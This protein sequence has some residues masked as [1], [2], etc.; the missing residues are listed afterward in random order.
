M[1]NT[2]SFI[3][4]IASYTSILQNIILALSGT[5]ATLF[6]FLGLTAWRKEIKGKS[7]YEKAKKV[8][9]AVYKVYRAFVYVR[10]PAIFQYEY[11]KEMTESWGHLKEEFYYEGECYVYDNRW[12]ILTEAFLELEEQNLD[13]QVEWG[14]EFQEIIVPLRKCKGKLLNAIQN[15][16]ETKKKNSQAP[17]CDIMAERAILY[18]EKDDKFTIEINKA[19]KLFENKLRPH[20]KK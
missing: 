10:N 6:A 4:Q 5:A 12:K 11:P 2:I 15:I 19:I 16:L 14:T 17:M 13:A 7:E 18:Y 9:K 1:T 3:S 20:I 8:L